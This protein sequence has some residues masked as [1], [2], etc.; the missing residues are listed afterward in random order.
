MFN[1]YETLI[2]HFIVVIREVQI[3]RVLLPLTIFV[4]PRA[5]KK[6]PPGLSSGG[7]PWFS[8]LMMTNEILSDLFW[9]SGEK[10]TIAPKK[11]RLPGRVEAG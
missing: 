7:K 9:L 1:Q 3:Y 11:S 8:L 10:Q 6:S 2:F 5:G 4:E